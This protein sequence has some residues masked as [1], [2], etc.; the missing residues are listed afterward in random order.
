MYTVCIVVLI[1]DNGGV[2][3]FGSGTG[4]QLGLGGTKDVY[5]VTKWFVCMLVIIFKIS[6]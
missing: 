1:T 5:Q 3:T 4:G 2:L 6:S